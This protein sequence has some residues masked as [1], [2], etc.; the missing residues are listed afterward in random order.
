M[1]SGGTLGVASPSSLQAIRRCGL[2]QY[3]RM[4]EYAGGG[5]SASSPK[6][7]LGNAAHEVLEWVAL[8]VES[9]GDSQDLAA[10]TRMRWNEA[11][12]R[13]AALSR[14]HPAESV[15]GG[16]EIWPDGPL[17]KERVLIE[18]ERLADELAHVPLEHR[19]PEWSLKSELLSL[20][21]SID[22]CTTTPEGTARIVDYKALAVHPKD[23]APDGRYRDQILIYAALV[24]DAGYAPVHAEVRPMGRRPLEVSIGPLE[25]EAAVEQAHRDLDLY[26]SAVAGGD[27]ESLARPSEDA[28]KW[29]QFAPSCSPMW[30]AAPGALGEMQAVA[31]A[32][33]H[34]GTSARGFV[35]LRVDSVSGTIVGEVT[36]AR[37]DPRRVPAVE[38]L[39]VGDT[40]KATGLQL[41]APEG[42]ALLARNSSW[43]RIESDSQQSA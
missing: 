31:G 43:V 10:E 16:P 32:V 26:N 37:L 1:S 18:A 38:H 36:I 17:V 30:S 25:V 39:A 15:F 5:E 19:H 11:L 3:R 4:R 23:V 9:A 21:G 24:Q 35:D 34:I 28:C 40:I 42:R 22:L 8:N 12:T 41:A 29:C 20:R 33:T 14:Q 27:P 6:A 13:Q 7:R 2:A